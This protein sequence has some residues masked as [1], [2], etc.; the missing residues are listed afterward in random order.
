MSNRKRDWLIAYDITCARRRRRIAGCLEDHAFRV[1]YSVFATRLSQAGMAAL[2][3]ELETHCDPADGDDIQILELPA[4]EESALVRNPLS[5][6]GV[7]GR[8]AE[9][10]QQAPDTVAEEYS[11]TSYW[12]AV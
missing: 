7:S 2:A 5:L 11:E 9:R 1:Q 12:R 3:R 8:L 10:F 4:G 6:D